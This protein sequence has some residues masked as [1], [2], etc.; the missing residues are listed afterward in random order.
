M[1]SHHAPARSGRGAV[2]W[3]QENYEA[4]LVDLTRAIELQPNDVFYYAIRGAV[5]VELDRFEE[6]KADFDRALEI[7]PSYE[8]ARYYRDELLPYFMP[9]TPTPSCVLSVSCR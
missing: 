7:D 9:P 2:Y 3:E 6:A 4:A 8:F 1:K 5:Y